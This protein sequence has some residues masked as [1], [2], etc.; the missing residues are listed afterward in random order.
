MLALKIDGVEMQ[1]DLFLCILSAIV[2]IIFVFAGFY[3]AMGSGFKAKDPIEAIKNAM[4]MIELKRSNS[5]EDTSQL[6]KLQNVAKDVIYAGNAYCD[7][8]CKSDLPPILMGGA[9]AGSG[10]AAM[11]Y[12]LSHHLSPH[13]SS[14]KFHR[15][16]VF[17]V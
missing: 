9:I 6:E 16:Q 17:C 10:V 3:C 15:Y 7:P 4:K 1:Y 14:S 13:L 8:I 12:M 2:A 11:H 5:A